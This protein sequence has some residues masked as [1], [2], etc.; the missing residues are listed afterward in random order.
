M[1]DLSDILPLII[2]RGI[3]LSLQQN[4]KFGHNSVSAIKTTLGLILAK[5]FLQHSVISNG[6][7]VIKSTIWVLGYSSYTELNG[8]IIKQKQGCLKLGVLSYNENQILNTLNVETTKIRFF[9][10]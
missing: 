6:K 2:Y 9:S 8:Q 5:N 10:C 1:Y 3:P 7:Y 4:A